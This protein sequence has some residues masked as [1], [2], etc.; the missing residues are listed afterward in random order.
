MRL[1]QFLVTQGQ[2]QT[3]SKAQRAIKEGHVTVNDTVVLKAS[4]PVLEDDT[5]VLKDSLPY[6]SV[7]ALKLKHMLET[8][9]ISL[10][11]ET[12]LDIGSSTGGFT[13]MALEAG[14]KQV[15]AVDVGT[16]QMHPSLRDDDRVTLWEQT[17]F[18]TLDPKHYAAATWVVCDVSFISSLV[19]LERL[20]AMGFRPTLMLIKPQFEQGKV[21]AQHVIKDPKRRRKIVTEYQKRCEAM[22][23]FFH[24][25]TV[26]PIT[27]GSGN[28]EYGAYLR[29]EPNVFDL[30]EYFK[31]S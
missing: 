2:V 26:S 20:K 1:D 15:I 19:I 9:G 14:A 18:L 21:N 10:E 30:E 4:T 23:V 8:F 12:V 13:Q 28:V 29:E 27:G 31:E 22:G 6:V 17:H 11:G 16:D 3:R 25:L 5:V 7:G 24:Q